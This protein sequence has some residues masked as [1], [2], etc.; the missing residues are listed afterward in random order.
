MRGSIGQS[1]SDDEFRHYAALA[2][3]TAVPAVPDVMQGMQDALAQ[4]KQTAERLGRDI[5]EW[6]HAIDQLKLQAED[7]TEKAATALSKGRNDLA[8]AAIT[9][10][11]RAVQRAT[12]LE[13]DVAEMRRLLTSHSSDIQNLETKLSTIYRRNHMAETRLSAAQTS[14]RARQL[15]YGEQVKDSLSRFEQLERAAD[16]AEGHAESLALGSKESLDA[17]SLEA[18]LAALRPPSGFGRKR[19]AS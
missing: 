9:E 3:H 19:I 5:A 10:R 15:L 14:A 12:E 2:K 18:E 1:W 13:T 4:E 17:L 7:W 8:R 11:H 16:L 6:Q